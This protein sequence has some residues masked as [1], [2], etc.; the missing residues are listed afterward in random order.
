MRRRRRLARA[1]AFVPSV[2]LRFPARRRARA[3]AQRGARGAGR[4]TEALEIDA[5][6]GYD[7]VAYHSYAKRRPCVY[8][9]AEGRA[10]GGVCFGGGC[11]YSCFKRRD[12]AKYKLRDRAA[13]APR[14]C[15][16]VP[17]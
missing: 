5:A 13:Q 15:A 16:S 8:G 10:D 11:T 2:S 1:R 14:L 17:N 7:Y 4:D 9:P 3:Q 6:A 12:D